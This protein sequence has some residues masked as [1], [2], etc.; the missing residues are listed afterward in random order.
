[1]RKR[2]NFIAKLLLVSRPSSTQINKQTNK[3]I[4]RYELERNYLFKKAILVLRGDQLELELNQLI[5]RDSLIRQ[6]QAE[7]SEAVQLFKVR[8]KKRADC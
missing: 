4:N 8:D 2:V 7:L 3:P 6:Q 5:Q 1:M